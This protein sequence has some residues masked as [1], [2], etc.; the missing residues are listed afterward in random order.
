MMEDFEVDYDLSCPKC[1]HSPLHNRDCLNWCN[2]GIIEEFADDLEIE[3][4]GVELLCPECKGT[5]V[6]WWCPNCGENLS[7]RLKE[8]GYEP[9]EDVS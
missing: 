6:E 3:G 5:G 8:C 1:E 7:G 2:E 9:E 4:T